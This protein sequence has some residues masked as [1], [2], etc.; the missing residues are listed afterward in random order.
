ME[1][2]WCLLCSIT[3]QLISR[4][5]SI[6]P[7]FVLFSKASEFLKN[8]WVG[9][10]LFLLQL[11]KTNYMS[12]TSLARQMVVHDSWSQ[13]QCVYGSKR[14]PPGTTVFCPF[15][16]P[17]GFLSTNTETFYL[18]LKCWCELNIWAVNAKLLKSDR[19]PRILDENPNSV[20]QKYLSTMTNWKPVE[21][22][23]Y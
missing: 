17:I 8:F 10:C 21:P 5:C 11:R 14:K 20:F 19:E 2:L 3:D 23:K 4:Y 13:K 22:I 16:L 12:A 15:F 9:S 7:I 1:A 6:V 18:V